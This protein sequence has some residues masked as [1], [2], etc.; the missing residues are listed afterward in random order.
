MATA[1][2]VPNTQWYIVVKI[3]ASEVFGEFNRSALILAALGLLFIMMVIVLFLYFVQ[4]ERT[5]IV[6]NEMKSE[7]ARLTLQQHATF[8]SKYA[9]DIIVLIDRDFKILMANDR[10]CEYYGYTQEQLNGKSFIELQPPEKSI[11]FI[12]FLAALLPNEGKIHQS[13]QYSKTKAPFP[14]EI[15]ARMITIKENTF[16]QLIIRDITERVQSEQQLKRLNAELTL[17]IN[18]LESLLYAITHDL[19]SPLVNID[20]F[21]KELDVAFSELN[22]FFTSIPR[23]KDEISS[24]VGIM[25]GDIKPSLDFI[26]R[27]TQ[28][29]N[30]L[31]DGLLN[32]SRAVRKKVIPERFDTESYH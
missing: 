1:R 26:T 23:P 2:K 18:E 28:K 16:Y 30:H 7:I 21:R 4:K 8:L 11:L 12:D 15:S 27:S 25:N 32:I 20:G 19:R 14:V 31:L 22:H 29:M 24:L 9:N 13:Q 17:K 3:A 6:H 5:Q 10:A